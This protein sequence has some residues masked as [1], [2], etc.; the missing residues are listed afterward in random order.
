MTEVVRGL[1]W[2]HPR[3]K[4]ALIAAAATLDPVRDGLSLTWDVQPL[5]GFE[6]AP[7]A[8]LCAN[9][10]VVVMDH[11]HLGE[12]LAR[13][14]L[15]PWDEQVDAAWIEAL[16]RDT[17]G[18]SLA[19]YHL[20]G[21]LWALPLDAA[22][23]VSARRGDLLAEVPDTWEEVLR[24]SERTGRVALSWGGPH[25]I[26]SLMS[27][28][29]SLGEDPGRGEAFITD[30][31]L[32]QEAIDILFRLAERQP[33]ATQ[34]L[35]PI[36]LLDHM[37]R[38]DDTI[39]CPLVYGYVNYAAPVQGNALTFGNAPAGRSG[40][41][42]TVIGGTGLALSTRFTPG[43]FLIG[44]LTGLLSAETQSGFIP[45]NNGQPS[46]RS[47]WTDPKVNADWGRFYSDTLETIETAY[48]RPRHDGYIAF[49]TLASKALRT[50]V[51]DQTNPKKIW[52]RLEEIWLKIA[53][54][55][56]Q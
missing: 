21:K 43:P 28:C 15:Q 55:A 27:I 44:H 12:A 41:R 2:D 29:V 18:P 32:G 39:Y 6:S 4:D 46:L 52:S 22:T 20:N 9:Y 7:I 51:S 8:E 36:G 5:E 54:E 56:E 16:G 31:S 45:D 34:D 40:R 10:D 11:P 19:S 49:Q 3:G 26:L 50:A 13:G 14:C 38:A 35:N 25:P 1:T 24:L 42:G 53:S 47:A 33:K 30:R 17:V 37:T 48:V 23:Q